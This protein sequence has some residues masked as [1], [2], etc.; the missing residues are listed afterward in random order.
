MCVKKGNPQ[1]EEYK[2]VGVKKWGKITIKCSNMVASKYGCV[3][4]WSHLNLNIGHSKSGFAH[5]LLVSIDAVPPLNLFKCQ[6][7]VVEKVPI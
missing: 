6:C 4:I 5:T 1:K 7:I 2:K 3:Q